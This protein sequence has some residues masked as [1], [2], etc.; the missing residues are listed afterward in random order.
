MNATHKKERKAIVAVPDEEW[1]NDD[2]ENHRPGTIDD[3]TVN[4][5]KARISQN[6][7]MTM[8]PTSKKRVFYSGSDFVESFNGVSCCVFTTRDNRKLS[9]VFDLLVEENFDLIL[10]T[11]MIR[12]SYYD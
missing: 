5:K 4:L 7:L 11:G 2:A 10:F 9:N 6:E 3:P 1:I 8:A 12:S